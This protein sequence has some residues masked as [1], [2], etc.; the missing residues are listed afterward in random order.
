MPGQWNIFFRSPGRGKTGGPL[1][2]GVPALPSGLLESTEPGRRIP[3][4]VG[5]DGQADDRIN[6]FFREARTAGARS[7][8]NLLGEGTAERYGYSLKMWLNFLR[9]HALGRAW[10]KATSDDVEDFAFWRTTDSQNP[11]KVQGGS[12]EK[13]VIAIQSLYRWT[14]RHHGVTNPVPT[15]VVRTRHGEV[16]Q[17]D[18]DFGSID[19]ASVKWLD[20]RAVDRWIGIGLTGFDVDGLEAE[21]WRGRSE[22]RNTAFAYGLYGTG[23]RLREWGS[24]LLDELPE[25]DPTRT[26]YTCRL[27]S[28]CAKGGYGHPYWMPRTALTRVLSYV[29]GER[30]L[31]VRRAQAASRYDQMPDRLVV[32][33]EDRKGQLTMVDAFGVMRHMLPSSLTPGARLRLLRET[34]DGLEPAALWVNDDGL[35]RKHKAWSKTWTQAND[36]VAA[37][38]LPHLVCR[39]HMLRHSFALRWYSIGYLTQRKTFA[40]LTD[41]ELSDF[42]SE[43]GDAWML[44]KT[45]LG[46]RSIQTTKDVYLEPFQSLQVELLLREAAEVPL[47]GLLGELLRAH[48]Q[49]VTD[50]V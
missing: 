24:V 39:P 38:G 34:D 17:I 32:L 27:P 50:E 43:F 35:P 10:D 40:H 13:D 3:F 16:E 8:R 12:A 9:L 15:S 23:L 42:R 47:H 28:I 33:D 18:I 26:Y 4:L 2:D 6:Q 29:E 45:M 20:A 44:V 11:A 36:R 31:A 14:A 25:D 5:P 30:A 21:V 19:E 22:Q 7:R 46:H 48:P 1:P 49:V 37:A 41:D